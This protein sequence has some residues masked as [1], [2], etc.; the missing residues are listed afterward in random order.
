MTVAAS[1]F[2]PMIAPIIG[3]AESARVT[4]RA[5]RGTDRVQS[6]FVSNANILQRLEVAMC[7]ASQKLQVGAD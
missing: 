3:E 4:S 5:N 2:S 7:A 6:I 1:A